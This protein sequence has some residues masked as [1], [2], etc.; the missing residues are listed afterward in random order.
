[1]EEPMQEKL[2]KMSRRMLLAAFAAIAAAFPANAQETFPSGPLHII[3]SSTAGSGIDLAARIVADGLAKVLGTA[4]LVENK[5][6]AAGLVAVQYMQSLPADG[7]TIMLMS[8]SLTIQTARDPSKFDIRRDIAPIIQQS[9]QAMVLFIKAGREF[10]TLRGLVD[11]ARRHP[12]E[13]NYAS[14]GNGSL[15]NLLTE[16]FKLVTG[17]DIV[18]IPY[19]G[20]NEDVTAILSGEVDMD[21]SGLIGIKPLIDEGKVIPVAVST[22][23]SFQGIP[24]MK[25]AGVDGFDFPVWTG[26]GARADTPKAIVSKLN[27]AINATF[28]QPEVIEKFAHLYVPVGGTPEQFGNLINREVESWANVIAKAGI[29]FE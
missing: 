27:E 29:K 28:R 15:Q 25:E 12:G 11:Y 3:V 14:L 17:T 18:Q 13:L 1:M 6:G 26:Y 7:Q 19:K 21:F 5:P 4:V 24:G 22:V 23:E 20:S 8:P 2:M 16:Q 10:T 9:S